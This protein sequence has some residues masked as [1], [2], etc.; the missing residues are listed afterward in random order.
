MKSNISVIIPVHEINEQL[1]PLLNNAVKSVIEQIVQPEE[2]I[3]VIPIDKPEIE[4]AIIDTLKVNKDFTVSV[5]HNT[6]KTDFCSQINL[7]V[8]NIKTD[9]F[10]WVGIHDEYSKI[11]LKNAIENINAYPEVGCFLPLIVQVN[12]LG[13]FLAF[14][15]EAVLANQFSDELGFLDLQSLL[16]YQGFSIDGMVMKTD[17]YKELGGLKTN[18]KLTFAYE[19]LLRL[20]HNDAK[21]MTISK[22]GYK[23][24]NGLP[25]T[26]FTTYK[27][28]LTQ[29]ESRF[30][31]AQAKKEYYFDYE[32]EITFEK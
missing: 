8:Q 2:L 26:L 13:Q 25:D 23:H 21:V 28:T 31:L 30:W 20:C 3:F 29:E 27:N 14:G 5:I 10:S 7:G 15:N 6:G 4:Q 19:F 22:L 32:R 11:W 24:V 17:V 16:T 12:E 1:K 18:I 9:Y